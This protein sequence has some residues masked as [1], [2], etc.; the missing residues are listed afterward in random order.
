[1]SPELETLEQIVDSDMS[2][3]IV[4][5]LYPSDQA[6]TQGVLGLLR[7]GDVRLLVAGEETPKWRWRVLFEEGSVLQELSRFTLAVTEQ[8]IRRLS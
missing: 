7:S 6:F 2:L 8:G 5:S 3:Q 1:M 4:R